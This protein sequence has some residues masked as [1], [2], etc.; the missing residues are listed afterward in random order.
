MPQELQQRVAD[1]HNKDLQLHIKLV[2]KARRAH[3][4]EN[5]NLSV[6][7]RTRSVDP[8]TTTMSE[9]IVNIKTDYANRS[10]CGVDGSSCASQIFPEPVFFKCVPK[11]ARS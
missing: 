7:K 3:R 11:I 1:Y 8:S 10:E 9:K 5:K 6:E 2:M 4:I